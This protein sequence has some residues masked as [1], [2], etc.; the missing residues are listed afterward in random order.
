[1]NV[2]QVPALFVASALLLLLI[3]GCDSRS[4]ST[5]SE[6]TT[7]EW[8]QWRGPQGTGVSLLGDLPVN[9]SVDGENM[10]WKV[11]PPA[12]GV[13]QPIVS[14][15]RVYLTGSRGGAGPVER[16]V[17]ALDVED[18]SLLWETVISK[19]RG[20][21]KHHRFGS[22]ATPTPVTDGEMVWAYFG[23]YLAALSIDG[24]LLWRTVVDEDYWGKSRYGAASSP[25]L[26]GGA[27]V[28]FSD[29]EWGHEKKRRGES[30]MAAY[31]RRTGEEL[32]RSEWDDTCCSYS[33]PLVRE[34]GNELEI[35]VASTPWMLGFDA[36]TGERL[37]Q[38]KL[39][40]NQVVPGLVMAGD[41]LIQAGS[42]HRK[43]IIAY[44]LSGVG[45]E[46]RG[47]KIW[48][49]IR[50]APDLASPVVYQGLLYAVAQGGVLTC[51][52]PQTG[53]LV[54]RK[55]LPKGDYRSAIVA[56]DGKLYIMTL[57]G[58]IQVVKA[59]RDFE[60]LASND[61]A[62]Y[63]ESSIAVTKDCFLVRTE[64]HLFCVER[65]PAPAAL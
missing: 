51:F 30:W 63:S 64:D 24:E 23:G 37:W 62:E 9:W 43:S 8:P 33:T 13:S 40:V 28:I 17:A 54:W 19:R 12:S 10:R 53:E 38:L 2:R 35:I 32:W 60:L 49:E 59:G 20:E 14:G 34:S 45:A 6:V 50:A 58:V 4:A 41:V 47:E 29:D 7:G 22:H 44:R 27:V 16:T 39:T 42:V 46:T 52:E 36:A 3:A 56:G 5:G 65:G 57:G 1:M 11:E 21:R 61:L 55:R 31:D 26:A 15:G 48:E 25:V 18:G